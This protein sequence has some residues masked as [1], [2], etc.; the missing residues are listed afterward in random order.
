MG[1]LIGLVN[2]LII[3]KLNIAAFITTL[4]TMYIC[5][6]LANLRSAGATF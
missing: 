1:C 3:T 5:R 6:G 2:G 4:G